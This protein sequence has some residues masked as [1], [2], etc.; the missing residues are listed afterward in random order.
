MGVPYRT[1]AYAWPAEDSF[2][3]MGAAACAGAPTDAFFPE[4]G[5][6]YATGKAICARCPVIAE[7]RAEI[8]RLEGRLAGSEVQGLYA[9]ETPA[10]R[11]RRRRSR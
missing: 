6:S 8:D 10:Q 7:C 2:A 9:G 1:V 5:S 11:H 3:W 4:R